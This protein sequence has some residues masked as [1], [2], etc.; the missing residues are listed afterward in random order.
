M[1]AA[2]NLPDPTSADAHQG[3]GET[4]GLQGSPARPAPRRTP[5]PHLDRLFG[6]DDGHAPKLSIVDVLATPIAGRPQ[7]LCG[8]CG[9]HGHHAEQ[10]VN[11]DIDNQNDDDAGAA[12]PTSSTP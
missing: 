11:G 7:P 2:H 8:R 6:P 12:T 9:I 3:S 5:T 1:T 10:C 4:P